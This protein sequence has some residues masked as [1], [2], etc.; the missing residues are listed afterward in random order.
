MLYKNGTLYVA[1]SAGTLYAIQTSSY[2]YQKGSPWP[3][4]GHDNGHTFNAG[5][6]YTSV[7]EETQKQENTPYEFSLLGNYPNPFNSSTTISFNINKPG[8]VE[9]S[10]YNL[11]GQKIAVVND[12]YLSSGNHSIV[13]NAEGCSSGLFI[14]QMKFGSKYST[15]RAMLIK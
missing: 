4:Y 9:I 11:Q 15:I 1:D 12:G 3:C 5:T 8:K 6:V 14:V 7:E 13:W 2:G 10:V